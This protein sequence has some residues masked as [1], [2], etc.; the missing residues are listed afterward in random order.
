MA[1]ANVRFVALHMRR[2]CVRVGAGSSGL[3]WRATLYTKFGLSVWASSLRYMGSAELIRQ[4]LS[5]NRKAAT[6]LG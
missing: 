3:P 4:M 5:L 1:L 6:S 2:S